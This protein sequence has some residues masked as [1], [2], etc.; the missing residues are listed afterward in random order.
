MEFI[1]RKLNLKD[2]L[3]KKSVLLFGPRQSGKSFLVKNMDDSIFSLKI[4]LLDGKTKFQVL[5]NPSYLKEIVELKNLHDC[6]IFIDEI[7][8][9]SQMLDEVHLLIEERN[10][11]FLMT[12]S[13][14]RKLR[15]KGTNLLG[16][17]AW[18]KFLFP[19]TYSEIGNHKNYNLPF[20]F[21]HGLLPSMFLAD[22]DDIEENLSAYVGT[23]LTEEI[24]AE[25]TSRNLSNFSR[26]LKTAALTNG[27][28]INFSNIASDSQVPVQTVKQWYQVLTDTL[29]GFFI[30][31]YQGCNKRKSINSSKF[32]F[33]DI[34]IVRTLKN[35]EVPL[36]G[37]NE[38]GEFFEQLICME[39]RAWIN[40]TRPKSKLTY[41]RT[42]TGIE[43]D[44]CID[45]EF[46]IEVK[47]TENVQEKHL[48]GLKTLKEEAIFKRYIVISQEPI[49]RKQDSIEIWNWK[50]FFSELWNSK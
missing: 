30:E 18:T 33:F 5:Q 40:Y 20:I 29:L 41:W 22:E 11:R 25:A 49:S 9:C 47:S 13:S 43:V 15:Q 32:Y 48:K 35:I 45:D 23:Y 3:L 14:A 42:K 24:S 10:I 8:M 26:F 12:G 19:L 17:R 2:A 39:L 50:D 37:N 1:Q 16:G 34:A 44:F 7:Q 31:P 4:N 46:A 38:F 28:I 36:E 21:K 6:V 27:Q